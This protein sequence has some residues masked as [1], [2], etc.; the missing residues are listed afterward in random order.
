MWLGQHLLCKILGRV[1]QGCLSRLKSKPTKKHKEWVRRR[2]LK[3]LRSRRR[4]P[5]RGRR[6]RDEHDPDLYVGCRRQVFA[7]PV[8][9]IY[10]D[11]ARNQTYDFFDDLVLLAKKSDR[12]LV[13]NMARV[14]WVSAA[15]TLRLFA[16]I[17][18]IHRIEWTTVKIIYP[19]SAP[20]RAILRESGIM[21]L[22]DSTG[23]PKMKGPVLTLPVLHFDGSPPHVQDL[24]NS[25]TEKV[26]F[27][28]DEEEK[29]ALGRAIQESI[30]NVLSHAYPEKETQ[31]FWWLFASRDPIKERLHMAV[32]DVGLGVPS[33]LRP[34]AVERL[35]M[36]MKK[37]ATSSHDGYMIKA[38]LQFGRTGTMDPHRGTGLPS[39]KRLV[40]QNE[41]GELWIFSGKGIYHYATRGKMEHVMS[42]KT[43]FPGTLIQWYVDV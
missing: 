6:R 17:D 4:R 23:F 42:S 35:N 18:I 21:H 12:G 37:V 33:S 19:K 7:P 30:E 28:G 14:Q 43:A 41:E 27:E 40:S 5:V 15:A 32:M 13:L 8:I 25:L 1:D 38:A 9:C 22:V 34:S 16:L 24:I 3:R 20:S 2:H 36:L 10:S 26:R 31:R 29:H 11:D 39:I